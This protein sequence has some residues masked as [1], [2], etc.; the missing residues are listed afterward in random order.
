M[1]IERDLG[2]R[3]KGCAATVSCPKVTHSGNRNH[4]RRLRPT[5]SPS[6][7][8]ALVPTLTGGPTS[9]SGTAPADLGRGTRVDA[10]D[11]VDRL[12]GDQRDPG[13]EEVEAGTYLGLGATAGDRGD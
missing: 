13:V 3:R 10:V 9:G 8:Q 7:P 2:T 1:W 6:R 11:A 12:L 5:G 4:P